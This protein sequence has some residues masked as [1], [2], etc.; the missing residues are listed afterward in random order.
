MTF[1]KTIITVKILK[2]FTPKPHH[3]ILHY[4]GLYTQV[5]TSAGTNLPYASS[6]GLYTS[7]KQYLTTS[8]V[9]IQEYLFEH[10][11][12]LDVSMHRIT[13]QKYITNDT[14][15]CTPPQSER[16]RQVP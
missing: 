12:P 15:H 11:E 8:G 10:N 1:N 6:V 13:V 2:K 4:Y 3:S 5:A 14:K 9:H 7:S 16:P